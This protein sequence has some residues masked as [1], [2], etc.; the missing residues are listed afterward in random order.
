MFIFLDVRME[1]N[2]MMFWSFDAR[3]FLK[4][5]T[6]YKRQKQN[7]SYVPFMEIVSQLR[8]DNSEIDNFDMDNRQVSGIPAFVENEPDRNTV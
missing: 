8:I 7:K 2:E 5:D 1:E 6:L 3:L 4:R